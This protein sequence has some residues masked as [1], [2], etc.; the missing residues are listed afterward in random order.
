[1]FSVKPAEH[2]RGPEHHSGG[3]L[4][5]DKLFLTTFGL[6][7]EIGGDRID[8]RAAHMHQP[9]DGRLLELGQKNLGAEH[10]VTLKLAWIGVADFRLQ[11]HAGV[12]ATH[13][14][15]PLLALDAG[16]VFAEKMH[17][18]EQRTRDGHGLALLVHNQQLPVGMVVLKAGDQIEADQAGPSGKKDF[19]EC[20]TTSGSRAARWPRPTTTTVNN[21][22]PNVN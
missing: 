22:A 7:V 2:Q 6:C 12:A 11:H 9:W 3:P 4:L 5:Q 1:M 10:V 18:W 19:H 20:R 16:E 17:A 13:R 21:H 15:R 8:N 14:H